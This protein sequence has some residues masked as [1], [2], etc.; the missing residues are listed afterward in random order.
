MVSSPGE[1]RIVSDGSLLELRQ[2]CD[3]RCNF[4]TIRNTMILE[5]TFQ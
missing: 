4:F 1:A 5:K 2:N 3:V